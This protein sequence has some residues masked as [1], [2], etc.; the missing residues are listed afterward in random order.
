VAS[1]RLTRTQADR[2]FDLSVQVLRQVALLAPSA[3]ERERAFTAVRLRP[4][5]ENLVGDVGVHG[6]RVAGDGGGP[7]RPV[8]LFGLQFFPDLTVSYF[9]QQLAA[10]EVKFLRAAQRQRQLVTAAGQAYFYRRVG[11]ERVGLIL[12]D[13]D[14]RLS[15]SEIEQTQKFCRGRDDP[16]S[17]IIRRR[18]G[19]SL[20]PHPSPA[21]AP[22]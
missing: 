4:H 19:L 10:F 5:I 14:N 18:L 15:D 7:V 9:D 2:V 3:G 11:Y 6:L 17:L 12:I 20:M 1:R 21:G 16:L 8:F 13:L 22:Q